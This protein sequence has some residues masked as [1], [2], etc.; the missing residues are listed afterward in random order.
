MQAL[1]NMVAP[2]VMTQTF[3]HFAA[4]EF[5]GAA[6][7]LAAVLTLLSLVPLALGLRSSPQP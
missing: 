5:Y 1:S 3:S 4:R 2:L 7:A 6:F